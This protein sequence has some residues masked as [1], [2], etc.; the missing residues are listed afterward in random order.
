[1]STKRLDDKGVQD[2]LRWLYEHPD[3]VIAVDT[4]T[5]GLRVGGDDYAIGVSLAAVSEDHVLSIYIAVRHPSGANASSATVAMLRH[6]LEV[7]PRTLAFANVQ[8]DI[9]AL[10]S[11]GIYTEHQNFFDVIVM[12][13]LINENEPLSKGLDSLAKHYLKAEGKVKDPFIESE[14]KTGNKNVT[15]EQ[16]WEYATVDTELTFRLY[17]HLLPLFQALPDWLWPH[18]Q[19]LIRVLLAMRRRGVAIDTRLAEEQIELANHAMLAAKR[20]MGLKPE[21]TLGPK[22]LER[23]IHDELGVPVLHTTKGGKPAFDS[24]IAMPLYEPLIEKMDSPVAAALKLYRGWQKSSSAA[25]IPYLRL[26]DSDGRLR[27]SYKLHGTSTGRLSCAEPNLQQVPKESNKVWNGRVKECFV[28]NEGYTLVNADFS[29]LELRLATAYAPDPKLVAVFADPDR[30]IFDE[31]TADLTPSMPVGWRRQDTKTLVYSMQYGAGVNRVMN[32]FH[33]D[34]NTAK[35][36]IANYKNTYQQFAVLNRKCTDMAED[37]LSINMWSG[38]KRTFQYKSEAYKA[39]NAM[40][41]GG[42]ADIV[43]RI[44]VRL[45]DEVD[46]EQEC[47][48]LLQVHDSVTFEVRTDL[49]AQYIPRIHAV[50]EDVDTVMGIQTGVRFAVDVTPWSAVEAAKWPQE[51]MAA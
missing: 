29:Q 46:D 4:E 40:I 6:V 51:E 33:V 48:M 44:M 16:M 11:V 13:H 30:D 27:C 3:A 17:T 7:Q 9:L 39:M 10:E 19:R 31:M 34:E 12:A 28:A 35:A 36:I 45:F 42:A 37:K 20:E 2:E 14:K 50:M 8:F 24:K 49:V 43:E 25:Y 26:M 22:A 1:M 5:T 15:W 38:R 32:A 21:D 23:I 41:Q 47:R 18:K